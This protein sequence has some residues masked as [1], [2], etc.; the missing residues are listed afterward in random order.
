M[1]H[2]TSNYSLCL[3]PLKEQN[4]M[5]HIITASHRLHISGLVQIHALPEGLRDV[6]FNP[7]LLHRSIGMGV[8]TGVCWF[9]TILLKYL[10]GI[11]LIFFGNQLYIL[12]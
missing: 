7:T 9:R 1:I 3:S 12:G 2:F 6:T 10:T 5:D 11:F 8:S 4:S